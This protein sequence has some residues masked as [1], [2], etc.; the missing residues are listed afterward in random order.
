MVLEDQLNEM[1][2]TTQ[3]AIRDSA[4]ARV[5]EFGEFV[6]EVEAQV[7]R[8]N[9]PSVMPSTVNGTSR[10]PLRNQPSRVRQSRH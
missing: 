5:T 8:L 1:P 3:R 9:R 2:K 6:K 7:C 4:I 10:P